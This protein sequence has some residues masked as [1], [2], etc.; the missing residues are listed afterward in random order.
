MKQIKS[1]LD[2][3]EQ[4]IKKSMA[5][6]DSETWKTA[7]QMVLNEIEGMRKVIREMEGKK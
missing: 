3:R 4:E 2:Y 1:Y 7:Y 5:N 6:T